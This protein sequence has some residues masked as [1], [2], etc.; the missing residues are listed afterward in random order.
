MGL[1]GGA[2]LCCHGGVLLFLSGLCRH[3]SYSSK[4]HPLPWVRAG[5]GRAYVHI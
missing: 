4:L 2:S 5:H 3:T 1:G